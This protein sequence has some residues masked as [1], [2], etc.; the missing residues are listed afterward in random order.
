MQLLIKE[1]N[2]WCVIIDVIDW[3]KLGKG[4][5]KKE[6]GKKNSPFFLLS[7]FS[8]VTPPT[9]YARNETISHKKDIFL[10]YNSES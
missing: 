2:I 7:N 5:V 8:P 1:K 10:K 4:N 3:E 6:K 9:K